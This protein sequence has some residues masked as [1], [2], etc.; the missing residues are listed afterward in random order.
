MGCSLGKGDC[1]SATQADLLSHNP[2][3]DDMRVEGDGVGF[4]E[5][6]P[7]QLFNL[8]P[9]PVLALVP[10]GFSGSFLAA[11]PNPKHLSMMC[12]LS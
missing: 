11:V 9:T 2:W 8:L 3:A 4:L 7:S 1:L 12:L 6:Q 5:G 10:S